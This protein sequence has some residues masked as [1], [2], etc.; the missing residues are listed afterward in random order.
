MLVEL[1]VSSSVSHQWLCTGDAPLP[2]SGSRWPRFPAFSGTIK[3]LRLPAP[4]WPSAHWFRQPAPRAPAGVRVRHG[5]SRRRA[6]PAA[7]RGLCWSR[8]H[9]P[10][11]RSCPRAR[12]GSPRFPSD[13]SRDFAPVYDP[14]RP[15]APCQWRRFRCCP[16]RKT[17]RASSSQT[18]FEAYSAA[19]SPAVYASRRALPHAM[20]DSLPAGWLRLCRAG[21]EP[22]GPRREVSAHGV[23]LPRAFPGA[24][25]VRSRGDEI[26]EPGANP[27]ST[28]PSMAE[29]RVPLASVTR[30]TNEYVDEG[31]DGDPVF[32]RAALAFAR[33]HYPL[34]HEGAPVLIRTPRATGNRGPPTPTSYRWCAQ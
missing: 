28:W 11:Q 2:S 1:R 34:R 5:R 30:L 17:M 12:A 8:W 4:A 27:R 20:Q 32:F 33:C 7:G 16:T 18:D 26:A 6:G 15:V 21:V 14:G 19:S 31:T 22:A 24:M 29:L 25:S 23:L 3:A 10:L 13:P 9:S